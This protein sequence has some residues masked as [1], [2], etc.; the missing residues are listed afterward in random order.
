MRDVKGGTRIRGLVVPKKYMALIQRE[1]DDA[2]KSRIT[3][4]TLSKR[5][6]KPKIKNTPTNSITPTAYTDN[7][8][9]K[10]IKESTVG[11]DEVTRNM[12]NP[13][14]PPQPTPANVQPQEGAGFNN[15]MS[16]F[17]DLYRRRAKYYQ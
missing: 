16:D 1:Y 7:I 2:L 17:I 13:N 10:A 6:P 11:N 15:I 9:S 3:S 12:D 14:R 8:L 4:N 5:Q